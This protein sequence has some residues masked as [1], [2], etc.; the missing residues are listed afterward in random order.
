MLP[1]ISSLRTQYCN[2]PSTFK[3]L[4]A[5]FSVHKLLYD[6]TSGKVSRITYKNLTFSNPSLPFSVRQTPSSNNRAR[7]SVKNIA[8]RPFLCITK[9][10]KRDNHERQFNHDAFS[11]F[12][13]NK[14]SYKESLQ[15]GGEPLR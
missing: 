12:E 9:A 4:L 1:I 14:G 6:E 7:K 15:S 13:P 11:R 5:H 3:W 10:S 8:Q 2:F